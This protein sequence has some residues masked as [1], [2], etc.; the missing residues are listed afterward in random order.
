MSLRRRKRSRSL[1]EF[2][3]MA[4]EAD[5]MRRILLV[6]L[7]VALACALVFAGASIEQELAIDN[8]MDL[9]GRWNSEA[10]S[11]ERG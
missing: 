6:L 8:C 11:C 10:Q 1:A 2:Y 9:G 7:L 4:T 3:S 5:G